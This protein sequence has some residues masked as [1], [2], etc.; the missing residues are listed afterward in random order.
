MASTSTQ[1]AS[2]VFSETPRFLILYENEK[3]DFF[4]GKVGI[5][6]F[7]TNKLAGTNNITSYIQCFYNNNTNIFTISCD[8]D[9]EESLCILPIYI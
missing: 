4:V 1:T 7:L 9:F 3:S 6:D 2:I 8:I 5:F